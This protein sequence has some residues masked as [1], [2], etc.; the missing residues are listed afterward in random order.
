MDGIDTKELL[1]LS[2]GMDIVPKEQLELVCDALDAC[3]KERDEAKAQATIALLALELNILD[4]HEFENYCEAQKS[5]SNCTDGDETECN[6]CLKEY[7]LQQAAEE[8][9]ERG[10]S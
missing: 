3:R 5:L 9:A 10:R 4:E 7:L 2:Y 6:Y 1:S 8:L